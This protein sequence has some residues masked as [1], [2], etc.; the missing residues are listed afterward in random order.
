MAA[1]QQPGDSASDE[2]LDSVAQAGAAVE[3]NSAEPNSVEPNS[4]E[5]N[6]VARVANETAAFARSKSFK[7]VFA[8]MHL[9]KFQEFFKNLEGRFQE[10]FT[11]VKEYES[12][13]KVNEIVKVR[14]RV[15]FRR[16]LP[17]MAS[18]QW[19]QSTNL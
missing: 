6:S 15:L 2:E 12:F 11:S 7:R 5:P 19:F 16:W 18:F 14:D 13:M 9:G 1:D 8:Q 10:W 17:S 4:V 3:P